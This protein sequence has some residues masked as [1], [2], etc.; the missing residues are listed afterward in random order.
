MDEDA[1]GAGPRSVHDYAKRLL[2]EGVGWV[3]QSNA[4]ADQV[5]TAC[6]CPFPHQKRGG[7][8]PAQ[9]FRDDRRDFCRLKPSVSGIAIELPNQIIEFHELCGGYGADLTF[10][11][12]CPVGIRPA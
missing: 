9:R 6:A 12:F 2:I 4:V 10:I 11:P 7:E 8:L 3:V 5:R 1:G